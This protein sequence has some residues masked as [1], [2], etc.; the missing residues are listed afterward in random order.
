MSLTGKDGL[1]KTAWQ[2]HDYIRAELVLTR[3]DMDVKGIPFNSGLLMSFLIGL[4]Q[5]KELII[6]EPGLGKTTSAEYVC[7]LF[8]PVSPWDNME[9]RGGGPS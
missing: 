7:A 6:G 3:P 5:G 8:V 9:K 1:R 4:F 2:I